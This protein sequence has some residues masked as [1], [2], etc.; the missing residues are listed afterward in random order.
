M[1]M[2]VNDRHGKD[3]ILTPQRQTLK[4][5][6][7]ETDRVH[8]LS[9]RYRSV[10]LFYTDLWLIMLGIEWDFDEKVDIKECEIP[11]GR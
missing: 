1:V 3:F 8:L 2:S 7:S 4:K 11:R 10:L 6:V 5:S 9:D